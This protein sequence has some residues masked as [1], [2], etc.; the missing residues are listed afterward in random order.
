MGAKQ[1]ADT[2]N[3][4]HRQ[5]HEQL[6][7]DYLRTVTAQLVEG[8]EMIYSPFPSFE[9]GCAHAPSAH[10]CRDLYDKYME[11]I[12]PY[13]DQH[14]SLLSTR[15]LAI[16]HSH[17]ITKH[18]AKLKGESV[19][20]GLLTMTNE[21]G[22]I[23]ICDLVPSKAH[24]Q[25]EIALKRMSESIAKY[26]L[27]PPKIIFTDNMADKPM[28]EAH[29]P[30]LKTGVQPVRHDNL[31][32]LELPEDI[33][34]LICSTPFQVRT[35]AF[36]LIDALKDSDSTLVVGLDT[37][38]NVDLDARRN[39][40]PDRRQTA[41][42]QLAHGSTIYI[43]LLT[44]L[45]ESS[46][47]PPQLISLLANPQIIKVGKS[48]NSDLK[49]LQED[50][51]SDS[52]FVGGQDIAQLAK[53]KNV[54][55]SSRIG[56]ADL[57]K[58]VL[59]RTLDKDQATRVSDTWSGPL[60]ERQKQYAA[61]DVWASLK[62]YEQLLAI[63]VPVPVDF[64]IQPSAGYP[65]YL[66]HTD[67]TSILASG[68]ISP[69]AQS[70]TWDNI[71]I[72][73]SRTVV[74]VQE[75]YI[76]GAI[77][78][79]HQK[80]ALGDFGSPPFN[81]VCLKSQVRTFIPG[82]VQSFHS[83][84]QSSSNILIP[85]DPNATDLTE[86][87]DTAIFHPPDDPTLV[88]LDVGFN[89]ENIE[90]RQSCDGKEV[91]EGAKARYLAI[92]N[93]VTNTPWAPE[94]RS[95]VLKDIFHVFHMIPLPKAHGLLHTFSCTMRDAIFVPDPEDKKR[96][97]S[98]LARRSPPMTWEEA[99][100]TMPKFI[101]RH[102]KHVVPPPEQLFKLVHEI[103]SVYGPLKDA[104]TGQP[105]FGPSAWKIVKSVLEH[106]RLGY[107]S[108]PPNVPLYYPLGACSVTGLTIYRCWRGTNFTEGGVHRPIR[109]SM[110]I[111]GV[112]P[113]HTANRLKDFTFRHNMQTG[114]YN[115]TGQHY[116]GH[117]DIEL[118]NTCQELLNSDL[119]RRGVPNSL[120]ISNWVNG[121]LYVQTAEVFG[122]LPVP[123]DVRLAF[124]LL[125]FDNASQP[126]AHSYLAKRQGT[127]FAVTPVHTEVEKQQYFQLSKSE[128]SFK[129]SRG[130]DWPLVT[131]RWN[132]GYANGKNVFYKVCLKFT[133][134]NFPCSNCFSFCIASGTSQVI[135]CK[136]DWKPQC[137][138]Y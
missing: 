73:K 13:L 17:K 34:I 55:D 70:S 127:R 49:F 120:P 107:I 43:I 10:F 8:Q 119:V 19:F 85:Y 95:G 87:E 44:Q 105:L 128:P 89:D 15:G 74:E 47:V 136:M 31:V 109:H 18:I 30:S 102:V 132:E 79:T 118:I 23:R 111:S 91:D 20:S 83:A 66:Y 51:G 104:Q 122:I 27:E 115:T 37:E 2:L 61:L 94:V 7:V 14:N 114:T 75:I 96:V 121:N 68:V 59:L 33:E 113:C 133:Q 135:L 129:D 82:Y 112:S 99:R 97:Q 98:Y 86:L 72:S 35:A 125:A 29:F 9:E 92:F 58:R 84:G 11:E 124:G 80:R 28:L 131:R 106:I 53:S 77:L 40:V 16:D 130:P 50:L 123:D 38:W 3:I 76:P 56:L 110:P 24:S 46:S 54:V 12:E 41:V 134:F 21:F 71:N 103:F 62:I 100:R 4:L 90:P 42:M 1:F 81:I 88:N 60:T 126:Q 5:Q 48:V 45:I 117:F 6:E 69:H 52:P 108:D 39:G 93:A 57:C 137:Q 65:I 64:A 26:G 32:P 25:F 78:N 138:E 101:K 63:Q 67:R 36:S 22:E 116:S